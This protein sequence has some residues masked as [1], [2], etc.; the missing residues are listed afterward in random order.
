VVEVGL[1]GILRAGGKPKP[2]L[3]TIMQSMIIL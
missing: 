1:A 3:Q 2:K